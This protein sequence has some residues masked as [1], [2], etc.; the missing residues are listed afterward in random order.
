MVN[1]AQLSLDVLFQ[2]LH[3]SPNVLQPLQPP[4]I[5]RSGFAAG[6]FVTQVQIVGKLDCFRFFPQVREFGFV[7]HA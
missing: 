6:H 7:M 2:F 3:F 4:P 1:S 5:F